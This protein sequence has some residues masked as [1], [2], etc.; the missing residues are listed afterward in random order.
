LNKWGFRKNST[1]EDWEFIAHRMKRRKLQGKQ[2]EVYINGSLASIRKVK[3]EISRYDLPS[4]K[5][6]RNLSEK[7]LI[8]H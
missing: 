1:K 8:V 3:K 5:N 2:S 6:D 4:W 7:A